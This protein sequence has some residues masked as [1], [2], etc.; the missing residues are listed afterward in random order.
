[1]PSA[2][3]T[4]IAVFYVPIKKLLDRDCAAVI[5]LGQF[6][7]AN[8]KTALE[9]AGCGLDELKF[10]GVFALGASRESLI[11]Q[12]S[13]I[14]GKTMG[15]VNN[16]V[17]AAPRNRLSGLKGVLMPTPFTGSRFHQERR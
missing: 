16:A 12:E 14:V 7:Q 13:H 10:H 5:F 4:A 17:N 8:T 2:V 1:M 3:E 15:L 6:I 9:H 11:P